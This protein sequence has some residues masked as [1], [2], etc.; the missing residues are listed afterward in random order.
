FCSRHTHLL[1]HSHEERESHFI[2]S[3]YSRTLDKWILMDPDFGVYVT[4]DKG[5]IL[6][7]E[8]IRRKLISDEPMKVLHPGSNSLET[9]WENIGNFIEGADYLWF[10]SD[11]IFKIRCPKYSRFAQDTLPIREYFELIPDR[12][13]PELLQESRLT[14]RG[15]KIYS[16]NDENLFW[17][18]PT[19]AS[20]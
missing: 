13:R 19:E 14:G 17:L 20:F 5:N 18:K 7:V 4:D 8:E 1:P 9:A 16:I 3:V 15:K 10:L 12:Y 11:F 2:T 6:G